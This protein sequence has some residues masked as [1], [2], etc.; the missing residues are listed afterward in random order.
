[1]TADKS[2]SSRT[3]SRPTVLDRFY[4]VGVVLKGIDG[5]VELAVGLLLWLAPGPLTSLLGRASEDLAAEQSEIRRTLAEYVA[6]LDHD[7]SYGPL[8]FVIFFLILH[9]V[10]KLALVYCLLKKLYWA[11][12]F[13]LALLSLF[14]VY[15]VYALLTRPTVWM[16]I[17]TLL[18]VAIIYLVYREYRE[19]RAE[20]ASARMDKPD[21]DRPDA[22]RPDADKPDA[23]K[24]D[25]DETG[26]ASS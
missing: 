20:A 19:I 15:Q 23:D 18:D 25:A 9:G 5:A 12:P 24:P 10:V 26:G 1:M 22:D 3:R 11:Y 21:A 7:L 8:T 14:L 2:G 6:R 13:A 4:D 17:F 16:L